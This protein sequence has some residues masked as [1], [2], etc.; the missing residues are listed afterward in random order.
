MEL[1]KHVLPASVLGEPARGGALGGHRPAAHGPRPRRRGGARGGREDG[2]RVSPAAQR[3]SPGLT[4][5]AALSHPLSEFEVR[6]GAWYLLGP[7]RPAP[8][9]PSGCAR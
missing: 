6:I 7:P 3:L 1:E 8:L 5:S 2:A 4:C 9:R